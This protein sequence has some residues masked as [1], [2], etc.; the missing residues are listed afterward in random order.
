MKRKFYGVLATILLVSIC[1]SFGDFSGFEELLSLSPSG[2]GMVVCVENY[3]NL[4]RNEFRRSVVE[5]II[6]GEPSRSSQQTRQVG[7]ISAKLDALEQAAGFR[8]ISENLEPLIGEKVVL[9]F[10]GVGDMEFVYITHLPITPPIL[11]NP[12][13][14]YEK[15][16]RNDVEYWTAQRERQGAW[17]GFFIKDGILVMSNSQ[18]QFERVLDI[19][20]GENKNNIYAD[21]TTITSLKYCGFSKDIGQAAVVLN[22]SILRDDPY[23]RRYYQGV[24]PERQ[25]FSRVA[26]N[27]AFDGKTAQIT[28]ISIPDREAKMPEN[29]RI[30]MLIEHCPKNTLMFQEF[31]ALIDERC[32]GSCILL[33]F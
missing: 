13:E 28:R 32:E 6:S 14:W 21:D 15:H 26:F 23:Y 27:F 19:V 24:F 18:K 4:R 10:Y 30:P 8:F 16:R 5:P 12:R 22:T 31:S 11:E 29:R 33:L 20:A 2:A 9:A 1:S 17:G 3:K 7:K 25:N